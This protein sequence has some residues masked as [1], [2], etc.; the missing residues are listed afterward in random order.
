MRCRHF[1][2]FTYEQ[3]KREITLTIRKMGKVFLTRESKV[4]ARILFNVAEIGLGGRL[5]G[6]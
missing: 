6:A 1:S 2:C 4:Y 3:Y 5:I